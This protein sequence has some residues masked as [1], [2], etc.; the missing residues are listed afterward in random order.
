MD[1]EYHLMIDGLVRFGNKI[2]V[3]D[4]SELK[5]LILREF[6]VKPNLGHQG[7]QKTFKFV[8]KFYHWSNLKKKVVYFISR[9]LDF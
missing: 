2:Y 7:Y 9:F 3:P 4:I 1:E 8:N 6:H 5:K